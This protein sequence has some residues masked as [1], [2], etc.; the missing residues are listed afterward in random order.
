[1]QRQIWSTGGDP[2]NKAQLKRRELDSN[3]LGAEV[4]GD[5]CV[6]NHSKCEVTPPK[7]LSVGEN[8]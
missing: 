6:I 5:G 3:R 7:K 8:L 1:M 4:P 2:D